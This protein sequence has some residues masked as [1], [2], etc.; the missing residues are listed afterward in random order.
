MVRV[1]GSGVGGASGDRRWGARSIPGIRKRISW[2]QIRGGIGSQRPGPPPNV[3][4]PQECRALVQPHL[5]E[6]IAVFLLE[7]PDLPEGVHHLRGN[8]QLPSP[9]VPEGIF[10]TFR[11][12][13]DSTAARVFQTGGLC[14]GRSVK[15]SVQAGVSFAGL[16]TRVLTG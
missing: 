14:E 5:L 4:R 3:E 7:R 12:K 6:V 15:G 10:G 2:P 13:M 9:G 11:L 1:T 16:F 8:A